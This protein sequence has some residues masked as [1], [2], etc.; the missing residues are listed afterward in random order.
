MILNG[1]ATSQCLAMAFSNNSMNY[2][3]PARA[4]QQSVITKSEEG[5]NRAVTTVMKNLSSAREVFFFF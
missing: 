5:M 2:N 3:L 1:L 4:K